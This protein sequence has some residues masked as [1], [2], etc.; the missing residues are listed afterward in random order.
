MMTVCKRST[1]CFLTLLCALVGGAAPAH[2]QSTRTWVSGVGDD[3]NPCSRTAPCL[4]FAGALSKTAASG[5]IDA[6]DAGDFGPVTITKAITI[7]GR[8]KGFISAATS[9]VVVSAGATD[10]VVLQ[11]LK[12]LGTTSGSGIEFNSGA[13]LHIED[14]AIRSFQSA[15]I[16]VATTAPAVLVVDGVVVEGTSDSGISLIPSAKLRA[17][18]SHSSLQGDT[19]GLAVGSH[20]DVQVSDTD[21]MR[22]AG[23]G[24]AVSV[25][26]QNNSQVNFERVVMHGHDIAIEAVGNTLGTATVRLS[27]IVALANTTALARQVSRAYVLSFGNGKVL[28]AADDLCNIMVAVGPE[29][30]A[31]ATAGVAYTAT[32]S[33][34]GAIGGS[35]FTV[36]SG[37]LPPE[38]FI[39]D[40]ALVG[41]PGI[42][43]VY[44]FTIQA[45][46]SHGCVAQR[47]YV[48]VVSE[49]PLPEEPVPPPDFTLVANVSEV[50]IVGSATGS[51]ELTATPNGYKGNIALTCVGATGIT[52]TIAA[53]ELTLD[54]VAKT[55]T[56]TIAVAGEFARKDSPLVWWAL[57]FVPFIRRPKKAMW[58][59]VALCVVQCK[60]KNTSEKDFSVTITA[61]GGGIEK[62]VTVDVDYF[63]TLATK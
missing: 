2:A 35:T 44:N 22:N 37:A 54:G 30:L 25:L 41:T 7:N 13:S 39:A 60:G 42:G 3:A 28:G 19:T 36:T 9:A 59:V 53:P 49:P 26:D 62:S 6:L 61:K 4:T 5:E 32:L 33:Q 11:G 45:E 43:G 55:T 18:I 57:L 63:A 52:C 58:L 56:A 24:L 21:I 29:T 12:L 1:L 31:S 14:V 20:V 27:N 34:A 40:N 10:A 38:L 47:E 46:D 17:Q 16:A 15:G 23:F 51:V 48:L 50:D 8:G